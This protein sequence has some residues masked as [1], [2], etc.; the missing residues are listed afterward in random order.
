LPRP[1]RIEGERARDEKREA[2]YINDWFKRSLTKEAKRKKRK[3]GGRKA[4]ELERLD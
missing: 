1:W 3:R 4:R 2:Y